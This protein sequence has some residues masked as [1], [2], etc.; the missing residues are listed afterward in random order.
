MADITR[1]TICANDKTESATLNHH[2]SIQA[3]LLSTLLT[4]VNELRSDVSKLRNDNATLLN[5]VQH[6]Q[7]NNALLSN[8]VRF[9][10]EQSGGKFSL[11]G[12]LPVEIRGMIWTIALTAPQIHFWSEKVISRSRVNEIMLAC[13]EARDTCLRLKLPYYVVVK[14]CYPQRRL[15]HHAVKKLS[16]LRQ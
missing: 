8:Q 16:Q 12:R 10:Q 14:D 4:S 9:L 6:L 15:P 3:E 11:F 5:K 1:K 7:K 2:D 13:R